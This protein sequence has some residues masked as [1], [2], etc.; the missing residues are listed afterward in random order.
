MTHRSTLVSLLAL[1]VLIAACVGTVDEPVVP[2]SPEVSPT[3]PVEEV[4]ETNNVSYTGVVRPAGISIYMEGTHRLS[5]SDGR[6]LLLES[7]SVDLNGYVGEEAKL[8]GAVRPTV[9]SEGLIMRV[10]S[11][12]LLKKGEPST[13]ELP[14]NDELSGET[15]VSEEG[16]LPIKE[17]EESTPPTTEPEKL[18][19]VAD[20]VLVDVV[21]E[22][23]EVT[24]VPTE[25]F[26]A[27]IASMAKQDTAK[28]N[29]T[30][31]YCTAHIGFCLSIHRNWWYK[32]F[33]TTSESFWHV[34]LSSE[35]ID[36]IGQGPIVITLENG[37]LS[38]V[39]ASDGETKTSGGMV[40][41]YREW[42]FGRH[43]KISGDASLE[44]AISYMTNALK[45]TE[46]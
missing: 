37:T 9:E 22:P 46:E 21:P 1:S 11:I 19:E 45:T 24:V 30:Q 23:V 18:P 40:T 10:E 34:E 25:E 3:S 28:S 2:E 33:G 43:F 5:L 20:E 42:T 39:N 36:R 17:D 31:S 32:S 16:L 12:A 14:V 38:S 15:P 8:M 6:F 41:G 27:R 26:I 44:D 29:W 7:S 13:D 4:R 35:P